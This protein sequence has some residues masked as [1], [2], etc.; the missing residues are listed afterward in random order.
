VQPLAPVTLS[1]R[2][3]EIVGI[4]G[5]AGNGQSELIALLTGEV[6]CDAEAAIR[7]D[8]TAIGRAGV[9]ARRR[10]GLAVVPEE[11]LGRAAVGALSL[12]ENALLTGL[13][14]GSRAGLVDRA[15]AETAAT[16]IVA[17]HDVRTAGVAHPAMTLSG[18]NLQKFVVGRALAA[19]PAVLVIAQPTWGVDANAQAAIHDRIR[20]RAAAGAAVLVIS[21]D[22]D[23]L[24][25]LSDRIGVIAAGH[26]TAPRP[27]SDWTIESIG[28]AMASAREAAV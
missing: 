23:E 3:G 24:M 26:I 16:G 28:L 14:P 15:A 12:V 17:E 25:A 5:I 18:G 11:R 22:L 21:Q 6:T 27:I 1:V 19:D 10:S 7:V 13:V 8:E 9:T 2:A 4:A 20:A